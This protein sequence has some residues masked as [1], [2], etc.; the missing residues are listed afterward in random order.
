[1]E[2]ARLWV[3]DDVLRAQIF[4]GDNDPHRQSTLNLNGLE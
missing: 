1:M 2:P 3:I 4:F